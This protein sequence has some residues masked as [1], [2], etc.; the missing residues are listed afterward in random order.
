MNDSSSTIVYKSSPTQ[1]YDSFHSCVKSW[2]WR[3]SVRVYHLISKPF[4]ATW[5]GLAIVLLFLLYRLD[6]NRTRS[7]NDQ[8]TVKFLTKAKTLFFLPCRFIG[9]PLDLLPSCKPR[10]IT[11]RFTSQASLTVDGL[12]APAGRAQGRGRTVSY[13]SIHNIQ[14]CCATDGTN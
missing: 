1:L 2:S 4:P 7:L 5:S 9:T 3:Y 8:K 11:T 12:T 14:I 13:S 6:N 10:S